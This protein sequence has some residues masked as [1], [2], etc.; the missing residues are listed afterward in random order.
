VSVCHP[1]AENSITSERNKEYYQRD[2]A[3][4]YHP[5][6][7]CRD[8]GGCII[9]NMF[10]DLDKLGNLMV[11]SVF[12]FPTSKGNSAA[13]KNVNKLF[14]SVGGGRL[15]VINTSPRARAKTHQTYMT[16][17]AV[18][19]VMIEAPIKL[20]LHEEDEDQ[21]V[22]L[23]KTLEY[24]K[25]VM[26]EYDKDHMLG[27]M[28]NEGYGRAGILPVEI[29]GSDLKVQFKLTKAEAAKL[30]KKFEGVISKEKTKF[31]LEEARDKAKEREK[32]KKKS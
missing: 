9:Y 31:S 7:D 19:G 16:F 23:F 14:N 17:E 27:G 18:T 21:E 11:P 15:E 10:G 12:F 22:L 30:D 1:L 13:T 5:R 32:G 28:R 3:L 4:G 8:R 2:L 25:E 6:G 20:I 24:L 29:K 26:Q